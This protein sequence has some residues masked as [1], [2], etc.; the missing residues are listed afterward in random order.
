ME[1]RQLKTLVNII[2]QGGFAIAGESVGLTQSA[3]SLQI[4]ALESELGETLFDRS[5]RPPQPNARAVAI[6]RKAREILRLCADLGDNSEAQLSGSLQLGAV[7]SVQATLLPS[8]LRQLRIM[9]PELFISVRMGLS[10]EL[11][12]SVYRGT[13]DAAIISGPSRLATGLS[14]HPFITETLVLI[15]PSDCVG[16]DARAILESFPYIRFKRSSWTGELINTTIKDHKYKVKAVIETDSLDSVWNM[17]ACGMGVSI[18]P[19]IWQK[20]R[21]TQYHPDNLRILAL[22]EKPIELE[23]GLVQRSSDPKSSLVLALYEA[24]THLEEEKDYASSK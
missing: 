12:R 5:K 7:P 8:A 22:G 15:V 24:F 9:H 21:I 4:K 11:A 6:A 3:V 13:L 2:D 17:V 23:T 14:W 20:H 19:H 16:E 1:L 10:D 18:V